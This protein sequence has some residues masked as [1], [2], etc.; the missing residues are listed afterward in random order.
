MQNNHPP[1]LNYCNSNQLELKARAQPTLFRLFLVQTLPPHLINF[2]KYLGL[3]M[4]ELKWKQDMI[5]GF[6]KTQRTSQRVVKTSRV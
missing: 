4:N 5:L 2:P 3:A 6:N 1:T